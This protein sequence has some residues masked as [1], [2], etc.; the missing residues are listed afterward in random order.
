MGFSQEDLELEPK[1]QQEKYKNKENL[2]FLQ[3]RRRG[4]RAAFYTRSQ[5]NNLQLFLHYFSRLRREVCRMTIEV[6]SS[7][8]RALVSPQSA[9][10]DFTKK[11]LMNAL[12]SARECVGAGG[13]FVVN[14]L[15]AAHV[16]LVVLST[17][18][19]A[20]ADSVWE[21]LELLLLD[22]NQKEEGGIKSVGAGT[23]KSKAR[24]AL[25]HNLKKYTL[26]TKEAGSF[27]STSTSS[28]VEKCHVV[29]V[30]PRM[31]TISP[32]S[33]KAT[34][35]ARICGLGDHVKRIE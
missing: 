32:W 2:D 31:G 21:T 16:N 13:H 1:Q 33:S 20:A 8:I 25:I 4:E 34:D 3:P 17:R 10:T 11:R 29:L 28:E 24:A 23:A 26:G 14:D 6:P 35:I 15:E 18:D 12:N 19:I 7:S 30:V 22:S 27:G 5:P 9:L